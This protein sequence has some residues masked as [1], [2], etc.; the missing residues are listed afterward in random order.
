MRK[1]LTAVLALSLLGCGPP[2]R[3]AAHSQAAGAS[4]DYYAKCEKIGSGE[5]MA[6][7]DLTECTVK[8]RDVFQVL[9]TENNCAS[10]N[11]TG[12][13]DCLARIRTTSCTNGLDLLAT[14][15]LVCNAGSVCVGK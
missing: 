9:W 13:S 2:S 6:Y 11:G 15:L 3:E 1:T 10:I 5:G 14:V 12:F 4:C 7:Q 8:Q